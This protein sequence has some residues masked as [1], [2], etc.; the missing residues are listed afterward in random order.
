[1]NL[2]FGALLI[3]SISR[4]F[5]DPRTKVP[6]Q[7]ATVWAKLGSLDLSGGALLTGS[8]ICLM[9]TLEMS[10]NVQSDVSIGIQVWFAGATF[11]VLFAGAIFDQYRK[12]ERATIPMRLFRNRAFVMCLLFEI[13][14]VG[15]QLDLFYYVRN[16][17]TLCK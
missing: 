4:W 3:F 7:V 14:A 1:M 5:T 13:F 10:S 9:V 12:K 17:Q 15:A 8:A 11:L 16:A 2:P 6:L